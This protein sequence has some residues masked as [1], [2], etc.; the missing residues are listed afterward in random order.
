MCVCVCSRRVVSTENI[1][2]LTH[3]IHREHILFNTFYLSIENTPA[4]PIITKHISRTYITKHLHH[5]LYVRTLSIYREHTLFIE[6][7][8]YLTRSI[9]R[10]HTP[11]AKPPIRVKH[12]HHRTR[13]PMAEAQIL[14]SQCPSIST[15]KQSLYKEFFGEPVSQDTT[16]GFVYEFFGDYIWFCL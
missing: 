4:S 3:S 8:F 7:T 6:N 11:E 15:I 16:F 13:R 1:F 12:F 5:I 14:K 9:Y 2:Y 10:E